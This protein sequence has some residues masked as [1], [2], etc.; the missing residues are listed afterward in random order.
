MPLALKEGRKVGARIVLGDKPEGPSWKSRHDLNDALD[1]NEA[2][3]EAYCSIYGY[4]DNMTLGEYVHFMTEIGNSKQVN[5]TRLAF[6]NL[7]PEIYKHLMSDR[8]EVMFNSLRYLKGTVVGV[9]GR[10]HLDGISKLWEE[11]N[12]KEK[13]LNV[14]K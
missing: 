6:K 10:D 11:A 4:P 9:V 1:T 2:L 14:S 13:I 3:N 7:E 8:E 12:E 5:E